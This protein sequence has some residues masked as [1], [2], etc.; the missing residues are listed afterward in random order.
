MREMYFHL[1]EH[2][3]NVFVGY[4]E[5]LSFGYY[6]TKMWLELKTAPVRLLE[7][8][9]KGMG[10]LNPEPTTK[11]TLRLESMAAGVSARS[12]N[13]ASAPVTVQLG[14]ASSNQNCPT[15][16]DGGNLAKLRGPKLLY[17]LG[18]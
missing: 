17:F 1:R 14:A 3:L 18:L 8:L 4:Y 7:R 16:V 10:R 13:R 15:N 6:C 5:Y 9:I 11:K 2:G 12:P